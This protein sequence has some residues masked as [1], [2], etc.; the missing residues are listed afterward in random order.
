MSVAQLLMNSRLASHFIFNPAALSSTSPY[1]EL[2]EFV[3][4]NPFDVMA[5]IMD[6]SLTDKAETC[7]SKSSSCC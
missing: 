2:T 4:I 6:S 5:Q 1:P 7:C 3:H